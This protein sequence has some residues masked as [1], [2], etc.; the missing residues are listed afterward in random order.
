M[1]I[2]VRK[3]DVSKYKLDKY[4]IECI[5]QNCVLDCDNECLKIITDNKIAY[6]ED[7]KVFK[8]HTIPF[9]EIL[10][11]EKIT[12]DQIFYLSGFDLY[13]KDYNYPD[14]TILDR[15]LCVV[16]SGVNDKHEVFKQSRVSITKD[17]IDPTIGKD[18]DLG[19]GTATTG[20]IAYLLPYA[21]IVSIKI[22]GQYKSEASVS[23]F[24]K[25]LQKCVDYNCAVV[26]MSLGGYVS[27][28]E[29]KTLD[30]SIRD[31]YYYKQI[32]II[33]AV[34]NEGL[35][36]ASY[37]ARSDYVIAV[38]SVNKWMSK[39]FFSNT[40]L[41]KDKP[42]VYFFGENLLLPHFGGVNE[43][44]EK[45]G[46]SF[47]T[48]V[49][50]AFAYLIYYHYYLA[51]L[52][53]IRSIRYDRDAKLLEQNRTCLAYGSY[54][55][56]C[57]TCR[58]MNY[59]IVKDFGDGN[60][61]C[62]NPQPVQPPTGGGQYIGGGGGRP[63]PLPQA[64]ES[65]FINI[66]LSKGL[67]DN[68]RENLF[69]IASN[70]KPLFLFSGYGIVSFRRLSYG[71]LAESVSYKRPRPAELVFPSLP[72]KI[73]L[74]D[75][76]KFFEFPMRSFEEYFSSLLDRY[77]R[78]R[79]YES[80]MII[81]ALQQIYPPRIHYETSTISG[82]G[83]AGSS[84]GVEKDVFKYA[85]AMLVKVIPRQVSGTLDLII[86]GIKYLNG[87]KTDETVLCEYSGVVADNVY[88][89]VVQTM[90]WDKIGITFRHRDA[91]SYTADI[92]LIAR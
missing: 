16:D 79:G 42:E 20:E 73:Y 61:C 57:D 36:K 72:I 62:Y 67:V 38:G 74:P 1:R 56:N 78:E 48:P 40:D 8:L 14:L 52:N 4:V 27:E 65:Y 33:S 51:R 15:P 66:D 24:L 64:L 60:C 55:M 80:T 89:C 41:A 85:L 88:E 69:K 13:I 86:S 5:I 91:S 9:L 49:V 18:D 82:S 6:I 50:S 70:N 25:A 83:S 26:N 59:T 17:T 54:H 31:M 71:S 12:L 58:N 22:F 75:L 44:R 21:K 68:I 32:Q 87:T 92:I 37:P 28:T 2:I 76:G 7:R 47:S 11:A 30:A 3:E 90:L 34:G 53:Q 35:F 84:T 63:R 10:G 77:F 23:D 81:Q 43:Y 45:S 19:H 46:T 39:S 29:E